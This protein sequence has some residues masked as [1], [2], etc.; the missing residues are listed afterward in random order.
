MP[1]PAPA[2][3]GVLA[4]SLVTLACVVALELIAWRALAQSQ[5]PEVQPAP[6]EALHP[7]RLLEPVELTLPEGVIVP[8][9]IEV[10]LAI[11]AEGR[12]TAVELQQSLGEAGD[13]AVREAALRLRFDPARRGAQPI[14]S[15]IGFRFEVIAK[16]PAPAV[17][18]GG[19]PPPPG[20]ATSGANAAVG[21][22]TAPAPDAPGAAAAAPVP[23]LDPDAESGPELGAVAR[24]DKPEPGAATRVKLRGRE[25]TMIPGTFGEPLRVVAT[26]PGVARS[27]FGLG[28]F[29][30]RGAA[31]QNTGFFVDGFA[32]PIL[33]HF[34]AGPAILSSR[35]VEQLDFYPGGFPVSYGRYTAGVIA[36]RTAPPPSDRLQLE[37]EV[38]LLRASGL[39][40]V[41]F[42]DG[43]GSVAVAFRR[44][45][46]ELILPLIT[47]DVTLSY[48]DYQLRMDYRFSDRLRASV[49]F[50]GSRD[51]FA[52]QQQTGAGATTGTSSA[53]LDYEFDQL[54]LSLEWKPLAELTLRWSGTAGPSGIDFGSEGTGDPS[55]GADTSTLRL[56]QRLDTVYA[57]TPALQTTL[58]FEESVYIHEVQGSVPSFGELPGIPA[59]EFTG[60]AIPFQDRISELELA[61]YLE[62]VWRPWRFE[63]TGGVRA[64][65]LKY[66]DFA[67]WVTDPR[68]VVR[69]KLTERAKLKLA[70]GLFAQPPLPFQIL[71]DSGNP[72]LAPNRA[73]QS[74]AGAELMLPLSI[75]IDT[76]LFYSHMWQLTRATGRVSID[77]DGDVIRPFFDDDGKG[78]AYGFELLVRRRVEQGLFGWLSYTL[79]RSERF[80]EGGRTVIFAFDQTHVLNLAASVALGR[81]TFGARF[82]LATGRPVGELLDVE[83]DDAVYDADQDEFDPDSGGRRIRLP[84]YHQL[85]VRIDRAWT[86][87]PVEASV[88][89][90]VINVYNAANSEGYQYEYDFRRRGRLPGLPFLPTIG[91]KGV[92]R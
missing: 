18:T 86:L 36:L 58:G 61:P 54:I 59:P 24:V 51:S 81:W 92:L 34:G 21:A 68:G 17:E 85:D 80:L 91:V 1:R 71:R 19:A 50:F 44:S 6:D 55:F 89:L 53:G 11:D 43:K 52:A 5:A 37:L 65:Y 33:Y 25:L 49:F 78:R 63:L 14:P 70:T 76:T 41:P 38:D 62:Q 12:V 74:S 35:L 27:P 28:F 9:A 22:T 3:S 75:E 88:Y 42:A 87:G 67:D 48:T 8:E 66:G 57:P 77:E 16:E 83:G 47:D 30:V 72:A 45:Y 7:P 23:A 4:P 46:Y 64:A 32:V 82:L 90:D 56:G 13:Q 29:L 40:I 31:F 79:S 10:V 60:E 2:D 26:L 84:T 20:A 39:A 73:W 15:R 69:F